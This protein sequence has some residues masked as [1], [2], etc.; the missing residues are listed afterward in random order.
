M[1]VWN[2]NTW[3]SAGD[4]GRYIGIGCSGGTFGKTEEFGAVLSDPVSLW[5]RDLAQKIGKGEASQIEK[6]KEK[7]K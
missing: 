7:I 6:R 2:R 4:L 3:N 1:A 5:E